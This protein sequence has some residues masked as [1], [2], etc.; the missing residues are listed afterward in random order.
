MRKVRFFVVVCL[1]SQVSMAQ[2]CENIIALSKIRNT[3]VQ[4]SSV[5]EQHAKNFCNEYSKS[6]GAT[7]DGSFGASYKFLSGSFSSS[8]VSMEEVAS[9]Y[10]SSNDLNSV[11]QDAYQQYIEGISP[12]A[13]GA[14][15]QCMAMWVYR[16]S[17]GSPGNRHS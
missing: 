9:K 3:V 14:Y 15:E 8:R 11:S 5:V 12:G 17:H 1:F 6:S 2:E 16:D 13:F 10:C 4:G 7:K